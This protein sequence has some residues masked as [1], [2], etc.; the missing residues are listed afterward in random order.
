MYE[1]NIINYNTIIKFLKYLKFFSDKSINIQFK[2]T[3][4]GNLKL[5]LIIRYS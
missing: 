3:L 4:N 1:I 5:I 2:F